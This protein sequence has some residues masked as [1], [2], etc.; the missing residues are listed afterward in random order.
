[1]PDARPVTADDSEALV[2]PVT[3]EELVVGKQRVVTGGVRLEKRVYEHE[4]TV[5]EPGF[6]E[7]V[8]VERVPVGRELEGPAEVRYEGETMIVPIMEE[9]LVVTRRLVLKE[10]VR[11][12]RH[13]REVHDPQRVTLRHEEAHLTPLGAKSVEGEDETDHGLAGQRARPVADGSDME[14]SNGENR[15]G[16][17]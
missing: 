8:E 7:E 1:M 16:H 11:I 5:D 4:E 15:R 13:R 6:T 12:T 2:V 9:Q 17:V 10:E 14:G 3:A